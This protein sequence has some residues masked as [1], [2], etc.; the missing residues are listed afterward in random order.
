[1]KTKQMMKTRQLMKL[2]QLMEQSQHSC[3]WTR[4]TTMELTSLH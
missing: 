4:M 1:M 3:R 2:S